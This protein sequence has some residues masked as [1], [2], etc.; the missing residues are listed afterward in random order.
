MD[1]SQ[2]TADLIAYAKADPLPVAA[3]ALLVLMFFKRYP[4]TMLKGALAVAVFLFAAHLV[5]GMMDSGGDLKDAAYKKSI[6]IMEG[7]G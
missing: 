1:L 5:S 3:T 7:D 2:I 6:A 4:K